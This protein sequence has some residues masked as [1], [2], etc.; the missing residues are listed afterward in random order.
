MS[1]AK[2]IKSPE[3]EI[4]FCAVKRPVMNKHKGVEEYSCRVHFE[5]TESGWD[6]FKGKL[7]K[8]NGMI[9]APDKKS[10]KGFNVKAANR[11]KPIVILNGKQLSDDEIPMIESGRGRLV[12]KP[13]ESKAGSGIRLIA[14]ELKSFEEYQ[15]GDDVDVDSVLDLLKD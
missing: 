2:N 13:F 3:G 14:V 12:V 1:D 10:G 6:E 5:G 11:S 4:T 7:D 8:V 15:K 9:A